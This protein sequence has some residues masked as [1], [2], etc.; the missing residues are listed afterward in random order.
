MIYMEQDINSYEI[1][2]VSVDELTDYLNKSLEAW[3]RPST[4]DYTVFQPIVELR[5]DIVETHANHIAKTDDSLL[6]YCTMVMPYHRRQAVWE[7]IRNAIKTLRTYHSGTHPDVEEALDN[8]PHQSWPDSLPIPTEYREYIILSYAYVWREYNM[9]AEY[10]AGNIL[11]IAYSS[12]N[13]Y[14]KNAL[15]TI[16]QRILDWNDAIRATKK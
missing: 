10:V 15:K 14:R 6:P 13:N 8:L 4:A 9:K 16:A 7:L 5:L 2:I 12:R 1:D 11:N 3:G